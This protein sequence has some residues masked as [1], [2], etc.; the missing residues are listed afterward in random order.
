MIVA[1]VEEFHILPLLY[2]RNFLGLMSRFKSPL[3]LHFVLCTPIWWNLLQPRREVEGKN[4]SWL[5]AHTSKIITNGWRLCPS[6][7][8][9]F[10]PWQ[11]PDEA[12]SKCENTRGSRSRFYHVQNHLVEDF[13][14]G[15]NRAHPY[16]PLS[17]EQTTLKGKKSSTLLLVYR[18]S[19][20]SVKTVGSLSLRTWRYR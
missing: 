4:E 16:C 10:L 17:R 13:T 15:K 14:Q 18:C 7:P 20:R 11:T 1:M 2:L 8:K 12:K 19:C 9:S 3:S 6:R 5:N